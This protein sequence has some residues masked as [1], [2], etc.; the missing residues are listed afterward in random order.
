MG[1]INSVLDGSAFVTRQKVGVRFV[2]DIPAEV[3]SPVSKRDA[4]TTVTV[5]VASWMRVSDLKP[6]F[7]RSMRLCTPS[8]LGI[9]SINGVYVSGNDAL[10]YLAHDQGRLNEVTLFLRPPS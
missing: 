8:R 4:W 10:Y 6:V 2:A 7:C 1:V 9:Q 5:D 3:L